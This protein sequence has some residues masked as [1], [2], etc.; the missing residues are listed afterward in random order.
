[1]ARAAKRRYL[2]PDGDYLLAHGSPVA[3]DG[4]TSQVVLR[5]RMQLGSS[6]LPT[7]GSRFHE[8]QT[9]DDSSLNL[10]RR[11]G[12]ECVKDLVD[13]GSITNVT[14]DAT[15]SKSRLSIVLSF[16]DSFGRPRSVTVSPTTGG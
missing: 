8:I 7:L 16:K 15:Q 14:C 13:N 5:L 10:A 3:D 6:V 11:Y 1:M 12:V 4:H 2:T 9:L